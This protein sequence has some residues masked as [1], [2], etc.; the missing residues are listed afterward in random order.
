MG[1]R[2]GL[3][4]DPMRER[5]RGRLSPQDLIAAFETLANTEGATT[6]L[7]ELV[8]QLANLRQYIAQLG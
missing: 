8:L 5:Q 7:R 3:D 1:S 2:P 4:K 6:R